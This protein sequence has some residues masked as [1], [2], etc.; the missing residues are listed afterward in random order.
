[1]PDDASGNYSLPA[2]TI[3]SNGETILPSQHNPAMQDIAAALTNRLN[4]QGTAPML[5]ALK[6]GGFKITGMANGTDPQDAVTKSQAV[7][8]AGD[9]MT[10]DLQS[11]NIDAFRPSAHFDGA[12]FASHPYN[13]ANKTAFFYGSQPSGE[14]VQ[15]TIAVKN[16]GTDAYFS[17]RDDGSLRAP[18][19]VYSGSAVFQSDGNVSGSIWNTWG[20]SFAF[21]A[22]GGRIEDRLGTR[23]AAGAECQH[24]SGT[25]EFGNIDVSIS[26]ITIDLPNPYVMTGLRSLNGTQRVWVRGKTIRNQ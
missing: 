13:D 12:Y 5:A 8:K 26:A 4:R 7:M 6:M 19:G 23:A 16:S 17:L 22:I 15:A 1:M 18:N 2:G 10:G 25:V 21:Q 11:Q 9:T 24:N 14:G 3:V 20:N